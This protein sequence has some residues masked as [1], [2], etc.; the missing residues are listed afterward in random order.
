VKW[1]KRMC[2]LRPE[3]CP[4]EVLVKIEQAPT[5]K[6]NEEDVNSLKRLLEEKGVLVDRISIDGVS[7][8]KRVYIRAHTQE[9]VKRLAGDILLSCRFSYGLLGKALHMHTTRCGACSA[10]GHSIAQCPKRNVL[11][12]EMASRTRLNSHSLK[13]IKEVMRDYMPA[14]RDMWVGR[15]TGDGTGHLLHITPLFE[16]EEQMVRIGKKSGHVCRV[17]S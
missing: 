5:R 13:Q 6:P 9:G 1:E 14:I 3:E 15:S 16:G 10:Y 2:G 17:I 7:P 11:V 4:Y 12:L 8:Q